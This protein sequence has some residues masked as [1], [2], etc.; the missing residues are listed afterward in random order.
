MLL[1]WA[2]GHESLTLAKPASSE[3]DALG[4]LTDEGDSEGGDGNRPEIL[5]RAYSFIRRRRGKSPYSTLAGERNAQCGP[6]DHTGVQSGEI[7][8]EH[9]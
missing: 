3:S 5:K 7:N 1:T 4:S 8:K 6:P 2:D 9:V